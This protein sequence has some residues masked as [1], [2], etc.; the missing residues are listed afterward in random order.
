MQ[1]L[2][3]KKKVA[4]IG[5]GGHCH[6]IIDTI[7]E[8]DDSCE[9]YNF[10]I[11]GFYDDNVE[12]KPY[13]NIKRIGN[14]NDIKNKKNDIS[15]ICG[16]GN[17]KTRK[18]IIEQFDKINWFNVIHPLSSISRTVN[19]GTG[20]FANVNT[21]INSN[22]VIKDHVIL[23]T[24]SVIEHD[25]I[26]NKNCHIAPSV[27]V[28]GHVKINENTFIGAGSNV[29]DENKYGYITIGKDTFINAGS[30]II[31]SVGDNMKIKGVY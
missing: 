7:I 24:N 18:K 1:D 11:I 5:G 25:V 10:D 15:Y 17:I 31:H 26:I 20:I 29:I 23:N 28:C 8:K 2:W 9:F 21:V 30:L 16:I 13:R 3:G 19:L 14:I 27:T 4:I 22:A 6:V 12:I